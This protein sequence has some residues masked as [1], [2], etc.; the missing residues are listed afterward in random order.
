MPRHDPTDS[1]YRK[2]LR[3]ARRDTPHGAVIRARTK[4]SRGVAKVMRDYGLTPNERL[5][6]NLRLLVQS[7][8]GRKGLID[9]DVGEELTALK[10]LGD[11]AFHVPVRKWTK[12]EADKYAADVVAALGKL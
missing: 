10:E 3:A 2:A 7:K 11:K 9:R 5:I 12:T 8:P 1:E 4:L 6:T